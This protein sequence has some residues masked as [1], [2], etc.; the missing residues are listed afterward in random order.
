MAENH[1]ENYI[2]LQEATRYSPYSQ[3]Y[4]SLRAR[5]GKLKALKIGRNWVTTREWLEEYLKKVE[6]YT[7]NHR[8]DEN[9]L[10]SSFVQPPENLPV[11]ELPDMVGGKRIFN[12]VNFQV[13]TSV[14]FALAFILLLAGSVF[15]KEALLDTFEKVDSYVQQTAKLGDEFIF[16]N[17]DKL[18]QGI[19]DVSTGTEKNIALLGDGFEIAKGNV[20]FLAKLPLGQLAEF[21]EKIENTLTKIN[22][23]VDSV[24]L[25]FGQK[26]Y[27]YQQDSLEYFSAETWGY[28]LGTFE[29][30]G[31]WISG[32]VLA[33]GKEIKTTAKNIASDVSYSVISIV[34]LSSGII[35]N[36]IA[37]IAQAG[38]DVAT[39]AALTFDDLGATATESARE[40]SLNVK[41]TAQDIGQKINQTYS[42]AD[43]K[44]DRTFFGFLKGIPGKMKEIGQAVA[45]PFQNIYQQFA[46]NPSQIIPEVGVK[47]GGSQDDQQKISDLEKELKDLRE[48]GVIVKEV[49]KEVSKVT[50]VEPVKEITYEKITSQIDNTSLAQVR[51]DIV[52]LQGEVAKRLYAP[53]GVIS[54]QV[55]LTQPVASPKI[56]QENADIVLQAVGTGNVILA[57]GTGMQISGRQVVIDSTDT[58]SPLIYL[59]DKTRINGATEILGALSAGGI[60][61]TTLTLNAASSTSKIL[62]IQADGATKF[63]VG[64]TGSVYFNTNI[65]SGT[66]QGTTVGTTYGG[67][68]LTSYTTGDIL[69]ATSTNTLFNLPIGTEGYVLTAI[70][71]KPV[72]QSGISGAN[73]TWILSGSN[74]YATSTAE[75]VGV[76]TTTPASIFEVYSGT[77]T[78]AQLTITVAT[79]TTSY[80]PQIA[81]R[82]GNGAPF[83]RFVMG[84]DYS[85]SNNFKIA[86]SSLGTNDILTINPTTGNVGIGTSTVATLFSV[87]TTTPIFTL[88]TQGNAAFG[89]S[90]TAGIFTVGTTS[91]ALTVTTAGNVG[92][93]TAAPGYPLTVN[94]IVDATSY[95]ISGISRLLTTSGNTT[96]RSTTGGYLSFISNAIENMRLSSAG[97]LSLGSGYVGT[98]A[99]AGNMIISG[100]VGIGTTTPSALLHVYATSTLS[101]TG[102]FRVATGTTEAMY[103]SNS[104]NVGIGTTTPSQ[105]LTVEGQC[106]TGDTLLPIVNGADVRHLQI[107]DIKGGEYVLSLNEKTGELEP[108]R[109]KGLLG[110]GVKPIYKIETEDGKTIRT[111]GNHPYLARQNKKSTNVA[112]F[113][114]VSNVVQNSGSST[115]Y[116]YSKSKNLVKSLTVDN[117]K[118]LEVEGVE[119]SDSWL[120]SPSP[121][122]V[123]PR[124]ALLYQEELEQAKWTK[125]IYLEVGDEIAV[126]DLKSDVKE[127]QGNGSTSDFGN[128]KFV[129]IAKIEILPPE[130]VYDIEVEGTHNFV[131]NGIIAHNTYISATTTIMGNVGI[132]TSTPSTWFLVGSTTPAFVVTSAGKIGI[133]TTTPTYPLDVFDTDG[134][135][136]FRVISNGVST[137]ANLEF[138]GSSYNGIL[139]VQSHRTTSA[140]AVI[141]L[142]PTTD[143]KSWSMYIDDSDSQKF[144]IEGGGISDDYTSY[145]GGNRMTIDT[146]GN[147]GFGTSAPTYRFQIQGGSKNANTL[148][149]ESNNR[150]DG[151]GAILEFNGANYDSILNLKAG[152]VASGGSGI[153]KLHP[154]TNAANR[155]VLLVDEAD[156]QKFKIRTGVAND[157]STKSG[158]DALTIQ[159]NGNVGIGTTSPAQM[160]TITATSS[161]NA[162]GIYASSSAAAPVFLV[163]NAGNVAIGTS[164]ASTLFAVAT[165]SPIFNVTTAGNVG[166]GTAAPSG[167]LSVAGSATDKAYFFYDNDDVGD[168]TDGQSLYVYRRAAEGDNYLRFLVD[169]WQTSLIYSNNILALQASDYVSSWSD[170]YLGITESA[171]HTFRHYGQITAVGGEKYIQWQVNDTTDN[172]EL[173]RQDTN[174][175]Y[176][177]VQMPTIFTSGNVGIGTTTPR[178]TLDIWGGLYVGTS[179]TPTLYV[180]STTG[181]VAIGTS[182]TAGL[183]SVGTTTEM[184]RINQAGNLGFKALAAQGG[185]TALC[186][187]TDVITGLNVLSSCTSAQRYKEDIQDLAIDKEK[188]LQLRPV[189]FKW[190]ELDATSTGLIAEE[191]EQLIPELVTYKDGQIEGVRYEKL[192]VYLLGIIKE[193]EQEIQGLKLSLAAN[194][195][196]LSNGS[197]IEPSI[198]TGLSFVEMVKDAISQLTGT[199]TAAG[200][201]VFDKI[202]VKTARIEKLEMVDKANGQIYCTWIENGEWVK[203]QG[204]CQDTLI[205]TDNPSSPPASPDT[206]INTDLEQVKPDPEPEPVIEQPAE[207]QPPSEPELAPQP[208]PQPETQ[209]APTEETTP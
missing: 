31:Q 133:G 162:F 136:G 127:K 151:T 203:V 157:Y 117:Q 23:S 21:N 65:A 19:S 42:S 8:H 164:T 90:T 170:F 61:G 2:S 189:S 64:G 201:W 174:I 66:W 126:A 144:K 63:Y 199:I 109:I 48:K 193:H 30:Y 106:V 101:T 118:A 82:T 55:Y 104:G 16:A 103:I 96:L 83:T 153:L 123:T 43:E 202:S 148:Y 34:D 142:S 44:L 197:Q 4:L 119:P 29:D 114:G 1:S 13:R 25:K 68:G 129:K 177:D 27:S 208:Q 195:D 18:S 52:D 209:L 172:F 98:D 168:T 45:K 152:T 182:T 160:L 145:A 190:K 41:E 206:P 150:S 158:T 196:L 108:A 135:L 76:G 47:E 205:N 183:F 20:I 81:F 39:T 207:E 80:D 62:D 67:T 175:G 49:V 186:Y 51:A 128:I 179:T 147:V 32:K 141:K 100:L 178:D 171:N 110:M 146:S 137:G 155:V 185:D 57:A 115:Y 3:E 24:S 58:T 140:D 75:Y 84:V 78:N 105:T 134:G 113:S 94:G 184:F 167:K 102:L 88:T 130:Q 204:E 99:G 198:P 46:A 50:Q 112:D 120:T 116:Q 60:T 36:G 91:N 14:I 7:I 93:G 87:A 11:G 154:Y 53:G 191:V 169:K 38:N 85:D 95:N 156:S 56:Y 73:T 192:A 12:P 92:I 5:S 97:G 77:S 122:H 15:G 143:D 69:I 163:N 9:R 180:A 138:N 107:K 131:A 59:A 40:L 28:T 22:N 111:T 54:Q 70:G 86:T 181:M 79:N 121:H 37:S 159:Q 35:K 10:I 124:A 89:T 33:L 176:F 6:D 125:V 149:A 139:N 188:V 72:W 166:I 173:T 161:Y 74:L 26:I 132:G 200:Q 187:R 71:G 194:G 17:A 165:S